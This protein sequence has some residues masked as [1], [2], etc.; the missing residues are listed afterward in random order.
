MVY[1]GDEKFDDLNEIKNKILKITENKNLNEEEIKF[2]KDLIKYH[3]D[4]ELD[5]LF[6]RFLLWASHIIPY[7]F[8]AI[9]LR[10]EALQKIRNKFRENYLDSKNGIIEILNKMNAGL[11][12]LLNEEQLITIF[13][14]QLKKLCQITK[15]P[16]EYIKDFEELYK[17][18]HELYDNLPQSKKELFLFYNLNKAIL[19]YFGL[20][21]SVKERKIK[22]GK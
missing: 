5:S 7:N 22:E 16:Y 17:K 4:K 13:N 20:Y 9:K 2:M 6:H 11:M 8:D 1:L 18:N 3:P 12:K 21:K 19:K 10:C 15:T 14:K